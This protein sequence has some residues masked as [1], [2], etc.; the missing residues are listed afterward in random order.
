MKPYKEMKQELAKR[1][2]NLKYFTPE[3]YNAFIDAYRDAT[4]AVIEGRDTH[5]KKGHVTFNHCYD[6][7]YTSRFYTDNGGTYCEFL[8]IFYGTFNLNKYRYTFY[9]NGLEVHRCEIYHENEETAKA[10][11]NAIIEDRQADFVEV[12]AA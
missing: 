5:Y 2:K 3:F 10:Y 11:A 9:H 6:A 12:D 7:I 1:C 4:N 8:A